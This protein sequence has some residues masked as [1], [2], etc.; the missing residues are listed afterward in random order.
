MLDQILGVILV[1]IVIVV[2][3]LRVMFRAIVPKQVRK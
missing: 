1:A 2:T 3:I